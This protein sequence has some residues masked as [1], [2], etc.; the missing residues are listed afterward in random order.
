MP[1]FQFVMGSLDCG[2]WP[3]MGDRWFLCN[4]AQLH[5]MHMERHSLV[6]LRFWRPVVLQCTL[7]DF[8]LMYAFG[9]NCTFFLTSTLFGLRH[10]WKKSTLMLCLLCIAL[11]LDIELLQIWLATLCMHSGACHTVDGEMC[12][13][14]HYQP[15]QPKTLPVLNQGG[16]GETEADLWYQAQQAADTLPNTQTG[17]RH[18]SFRTKHDKTQS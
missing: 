11:L 6:R 8:S 17:R 3:T 5:R 7:W 15:K 14:V 16:A 9:D 10:A 2:P 13:A 4:S 1:I 18:P 12:S